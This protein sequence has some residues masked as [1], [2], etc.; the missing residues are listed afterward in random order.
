[1]CGGILR[2]HT[3][4]NI[5]PVQATILQSDTLALRVIKDLNLESTPDFQPRLGLRSKCRPEYSGAAT[6]VVGWSCVDEFGFGWS[7]PDCRVPGRACGRRSGS[8]ACCRLAV[9][10][11]RV[12]CAR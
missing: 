3:G 11:M 1:M 8:T 7:S 5:L 2:R 6:L 9:I 4:C 12:S 10:T